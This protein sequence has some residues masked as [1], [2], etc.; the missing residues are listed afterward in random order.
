MAAGYETL[1]TIAEMDVKQSSEPN[2]ID[3]MLVFIKQ[4][5]PNDA[6]L[7]LILS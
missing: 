5:F 1:H 6:R 7:M 2:D 4:H 3:R